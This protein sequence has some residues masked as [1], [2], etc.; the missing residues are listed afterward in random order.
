[1]PI[2]LLGVGIISLVV[3]VAAGPNPAAIGALALVLCC[4][5]AIRDAAR[6][7]FTW[8]TLIGLLVVVVWMIPIRLY[9]LAIPL[10]FNLEVYR[11]VL[12]GLF[13]GLAVAVIGRH[14][15][16]SAAGHGKPLVLLALV[17][18]VSYVI[19]VRA[20]SL[21]SAEGAK[22]LSFFLSYIAFFV[23][24]ASTVDTRDQAD[25]ILAVLVA[26]AAIVAFVALIE[27]KTGYNPFNHLSSWIPGLVQLPR[28]IYEV[29]GGQVR[30][31]ASSQHPIALGCALMM[32]LPVAAYLMSRASTR[33]RARLYGLAG[34]V[35]AAGALVT[36][37][38]TTLAMA[39]GM[40]AVAMAFRGRRIVR[41][42]PALIVLAAAIHLVAPGAL[43]ALYKSLFPSEGLVSELQGRPGQAGSGR[44]ADIGPGIK[45]WKESPVVGH[46]IGGDEPFTITDPKQVSLG[47]APP[48]IIFDNQYM[49][50]LVTLGIVGVIAIVWLV[51]GAA[52]KFVRAAKTVSG[53]TSDL[54]VT[55][56]C[57]AVSFGIALF[58]FDA[59]F[60]VQAAL[61][62]VIITA[63]A[64][65]VA[66]LERATAPAPAPAPA[67]AEPI[68]P[69]PA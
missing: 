47:Q 3:G 8:T 37:S 60:F 54:M 42:W 36:V 68:R 28:E 45:I 21:D 30:V 5:L 27:T 33:A 31:V 25:R 13:F 14:R 63:L 57:V 46:G 12:L 4:I 61:I 48:R 32:S 2:A 66:A 29:R 35:I 65:R 18:V 22:A 53:T 41:H 62:F 38:R 39:F 69:V 15:T 52:R 20:G 17:L 55:G 7:V 59:L 44:F 6:P 67:H 19:N 51:F 24:L 56:A 50:T 49:A 16:V 9:T 43:G 1:M 64:L 10:P 40:I 58:L 34:L 26:G 23:V 11:L